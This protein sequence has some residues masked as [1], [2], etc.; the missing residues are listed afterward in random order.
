MPKSA[1]RGRG[2]GEGGIGRGRSAVAGPARGLSVALVV[3][4]GWA[5]VQG[6]G[7]PSGGAGSEKAA[8]REGISRSS[9]APEVDLQ[10]LLDNEPRADRR[11]LIIDTRSKDVS[12]VYV[13]D[14]RWDYTF[15]RRRLIL[16]ADRLILVAPGAARGLPGSRSGEEGTPQE[17]G[18]GRAAGGEP[19]PAAERGDPEEMEGAPG[20]PDDPGDAEEEAGAPGQPDD[21]GDAEEEDGAPDVL[22]YFFAEGNT[23]VEL[24]RERTVIEAGSIF[25]EHYR[26]D[27]F[28]CRITDARLESTIDGMSHM[29]QSV[30]LRDLRG[31]SPHPRQGDIGS[32]PLVVTARELLTRDFRRYDCRG[33]RVTTCDYGVPHYSIAAE[34][35][36]IS[37]IAGEKE[38]RDGGPSAVAIGQE[39][40]DDEVKGFSIDLEEAGFEILGTRVLPLPISRWDTRWHDFLPVRAVEIG[41][42]SKFGHIAGADWNLNFFLKRLPLELVPPLESFFRRSRFDFETTYFADRGLAYGPKGEYGTDPKRW[43][44]W[45]LQL[46][47][48]TYYGE[49]RYFRIRDHG[50]DRSGLPFPD[51]DRYWASIYH[52][53]AV[54]WVGILD[55][56]F[57]EYSDA[58]FL[59]EYFESIYKQEKEQESLV[60]IRRN[61]T[62]NMAATGLFK[63]RVND[64][65]SEVERLPE[66]K[67]LLLQQPVFSTGLYTD[68]TLQAASL[69]SRPAEG[70]GLE[71]NR[72]GRV[73]ALSE[74]AYPLGYLDPYIDVRP[75]ASLRYTGY[76]DVVDP[77]A[78]AADRG[79]FG[80]GVTVSQQWSGRFDIDEDSLLNRWFSIRKLKHVV[81][82]KATYFN[83]FASDM[84][85]EELYVVDDVDN[86]DLTESVAFSLRQALIRR[87]ETK[88]EGGFAPHWRRGELFESLEYESRTILDSEV[89]FFLYP[90]EE[91]DN[92]GEPLSRIIFD[93]AI[94]PAE[95]L[96]LR[97]W[98]AVDPSDGFRFDI[99]DNS[100]RVDWLP[101]VL[102][103]TVG[104]RFTRRPGDARGSTHFIYILASVNFGEK[105][106]SEAYYSRDIDQEVDSEY[107]ISLIRVFHRFALFLE[108]TL[109]VGEDDNHS[110]SVNFAPLDMVGRFLRRPYY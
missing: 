79:A 91:R 23:H 71:S 98:V 109:D 22:F 39:E 78:G 54:P 14:V 93:H 86:V 13:G 46:S 45:P 44:P 41:H 102:S 101:D 25:Y 10:D 59:R 80:A 57:S 70:L 65:R 47:S 63:Y 90:R 73:D 4:A 85:P 88:V 69:R 49:G 82:P 56:E 55:V 106:R 15:G 5:A 68:L 81:I 11:P 1:E 105:W 76:E 62:D 72:Y 52:R 16:R 3:A 24:P 61:F 74:W 12:R 95:S 64:F 8:E 38:K 42:S 32:M 89:S 87:R 99:A 6:A 19:E 107:S 7:A 30:R 60:S 84:A 77:S 104:D 103:T 75:F 67:L 50:E 83:L 2:A 18:E 94:Y 26:D 36:R 96:R 43:D 53:Q 27:T 108:Y 97:S 20:Q 48:W 33:V 34:R 92:D 66:A 40:G 58:N 51:E 35:T 31:S 37:P 9:G 17:G 28:I 29:L 100:L 110:I 21:P